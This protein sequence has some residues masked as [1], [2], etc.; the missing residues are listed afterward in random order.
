[1]NEEQK[2]ISKAFIVIFLI[3]FIIINWNDISWLFN[4]REVSGLLDDF[5]TPYKSAKALSSAS[6]SLNYP[7]NNNA[8][9]SGKEN[10]LE[11]PAIGISVPIFFPRV[12]DKKI[13]AKDL[14]KG[15]VYYP[16]SVLP[17]EKGQIVILGHSA[18]PNWP[19]IKNDWV[20]SN[21]NNL[22]FGDEIL[23][24]LDQKKYTYYVK[25]KTIIKKGQEIAPALTTSNNML[26]LVSCWPPGKDKQRIA[27]K[28]ELAY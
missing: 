27:V 23:L 8:A 6:I 21:I 15:V 4:Y 7:E 19:K 9:K 1:M 20:F 25:E 17:P 26:I 16:G 12:A 14:D 28:A 10:T 11:I 3:S 2:K 24:H 5:F 13:I 22:N 18:P